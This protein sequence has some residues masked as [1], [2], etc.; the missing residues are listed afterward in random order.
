MKGMNR[1]FDF[2]PA[3]LKVIIFLTG[4]LLLLSLYR[5]IKS[6]SEVKP[7][8][9]N[10][11]FNIGD[12]DLRYQTVFRVD[13][14]HSPVDSLDLI[15]GIGPVLSRRIVAY[16]DS[17]GRF[18]KVDDILKVRGISRKLLEKIEPY[19]EVAPW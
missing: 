16:R 6:Y 9:F 11:S 3:Q 13:L 4:F 15:P 5:F 12:G 8:G 14:N 19:L 2:S 1:F 18:E 17:A 7:E 10:L